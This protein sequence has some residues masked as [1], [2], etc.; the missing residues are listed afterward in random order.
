MTNSDP[1]VI[2]VG[3]DG[4]KQSHGALEWA[5]E[6]SRYRDAEL[7]VVTVWNK[8]PMSWYPAL[9]ETAAGE[10]VAEE[11]P[12]QQAEALSAAAAAAAAAAG[13]NVVTRTVH[14]DSAASAIL[15]AAREADLV[16]IGSRGHGGFAGMHIGSVST[17]VVGHSPCPV[18][19]VRPKAAGASS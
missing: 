17:H 12:E 2:V 5:I 11:S 3:F 7:R 13:V 4:S 10:I 19:V 15:G 9:L 6:E 18:L 1:F 14:H 16:V 8:A